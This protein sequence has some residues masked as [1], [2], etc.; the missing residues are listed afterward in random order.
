LLN[1]LKKEKNSYFIAHLIT[2]LPLFL[3]LIFNFNSK[4]ILRISGFPKSA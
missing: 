1:L 4:I 3:N 2:S